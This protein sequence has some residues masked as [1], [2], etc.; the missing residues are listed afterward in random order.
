[1]LLLPLPKKG[2]KDWGIQVDQLCL[3]SLRD[4]QLSL[5]RR[6]L[7]QSLPNSLEHLLYYDLA[8]SILHDFS[9][10]VLPVV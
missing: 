1:M 9:Q 2:T 6:L 10:Q 5:T 4:T 3:Q 7:V 8:Y